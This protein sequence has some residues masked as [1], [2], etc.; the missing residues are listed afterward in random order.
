MGYTTDNLQRKA[1][2]LTGSGKWKYTVSLQYVTD[3]YRRV[4]MWD[5]A[6]EALGRA[7]GQQTSGVT[8]TKIPE[9]WMM[10]VPKPYGIHSH[11][12]MVKK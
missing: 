7:T 10:F 3:D 5:A 9:G 6:E 4:N 8:M 1:Y 11:P 2:L 12:I